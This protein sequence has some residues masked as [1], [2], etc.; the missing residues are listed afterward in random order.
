[1]YFLNLNSSSKLWIAQNELRVNFTQPATK[2]IANREESEREST[3][4]S[5]LLGRLM[6]C[7]RDTLR[8]NLGGGG[9]ASSLLRFGPFEELCRTLKSDARSLGTVDIA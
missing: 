8:T 1:M 9:F 3:L 4:L 5:W 6:F 7:S 2:N